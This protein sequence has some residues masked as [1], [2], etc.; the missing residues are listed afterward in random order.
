MNVGTSAYLHGILQPY[1]AAVKTM[2][3]VTQPIT[4]CFPGILRKLT[5]ELTDSY[6]G[7]EVS[8]PNLPAQMAL[9]MPYLR[10]PAINKPELA[11]A[12]TEKGTYAAK[13]L[14]VRLNFRMGPYLPTLRSFE[15]LDLSVQNS[16]VLPIVESTWAAMESMVIRSNPGFERFGFEPIDFPLLKTQMKAWRKKAAKLD[17][18]EK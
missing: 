12:L 10:S 7:T 9:C 3:T 4:H 5:A 18:P 6:I 15:L 11:D 2:D 1:S 17:G 8:K 14:V 16:D 13:K